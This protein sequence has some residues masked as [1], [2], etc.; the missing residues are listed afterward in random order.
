MYLFIFVCLFVFSF[1]SRILHSQGDVT[2]TG[3]EL[4][5]LTYVRIL[6]YSYSFP[7]SS[8]GSSAG[9]TYFGSGAITIFLTTY[10]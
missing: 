9:H 3:E 2:I 10:R 1:H 7:L 8:E 6:M 5:I 4:Q